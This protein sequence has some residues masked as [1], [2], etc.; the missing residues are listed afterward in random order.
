M[1]KD[2]QNQFLENAMNQRVNTTIF[3]SSGIKLLGQIIGYDDD[4]IILA[5]KGVYQLIYKN[6]IST[7]VPPESINLLDD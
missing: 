3:L 6:A 5:G 2:I 7:L 4:C 1:S